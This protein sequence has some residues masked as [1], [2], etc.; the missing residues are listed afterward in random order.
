MTVCTLLSI[1]KAKN[2]TG[3]KNTISA[4]SSCVTNAGDISS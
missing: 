3:H 4:P 2:K 1:K